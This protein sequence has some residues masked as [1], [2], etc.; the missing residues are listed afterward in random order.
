MLGQNLK[1]LID[2]CD[3]VM[4]INSLDCSQAVD[5]VYLD[6]YGFSPL[7]DFGINDRTQLA[8]LTVLRGGLEKTL[9][10][11]LKD[12]GFVACGPEEGSIAFIEGSVGI[13][14][15]DDSYAQKSIDGVLY[16]QHTKIRN[17]KCLK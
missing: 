5:R 6:Y 11:I 4:N 10:Y 9:S 3:E 7:D 8:K 1:T 12:L 15:G 14:L 13:C 16:S 17:W 2:T